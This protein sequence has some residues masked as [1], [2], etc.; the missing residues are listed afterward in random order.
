VE[1]SQRAERQAEAAPARASHRRAQ[2]NLRGTYGTERSALRAGADADMARADLL[3]RESEI[4]ARRKMDEQAIAQVEAANTAQ[5]LKDY[6]AETQRQIDDVRSKKIDPN[7]GHDSPEETFMNVFGGLMGGLYMGINHLDKNPFIEQLNKQI[8]QRIRVQE[9]NLK[10]AKD[11]IGERRSTLAEMR[12]TY[13]DEALAKAQAKNLYYEAAREE[14]AARASQYDSPKIKA[15]WQ[16]GDAAIERAQDGLDL[17]RLREEAAA[18][19]AAATAA[20]H[21]R[22]LDFKDRLELQHMQNETLKT[23][24]EAAKDFAASGKAGAEDAQRFVGTGKDEQGNPTGYLERN[25]EGAKERENSRIA[26]MQLLAK[27]DR[28]QEIRN[29]Q[30]TLGR[31]LNRQ[32]PGDAV[33]LYTPEWQTQLRSISAEMTT[34]WAHAKKLGALSD[35]DRKL[36]DAAIGDLESRG[37]QADERLNE[38]RRTVQSAIA[39]EDQAASGPRATKVIGANGHERVIVHGTSNAP[40]NQRTTPR[41]PVK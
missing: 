9:S 26:A 10:H 35:S 8:E 3:A 21:R 38:L 41:T 13:K 34:D 7:E 2:D 22:H 36:A 40:N 23:G 39:A 33:Q 32:N 12:A 1:A 20:E 6:E 18:R 5:H 30:G 17:Q 15:N 19:A 29:G 16:A 24:A 11:T 37:G 31:T 27:I 25:A 14:L 4:A 28:V